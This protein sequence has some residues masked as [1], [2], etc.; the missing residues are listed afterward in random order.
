[1]AC[2]PPPRSSRSP[3]RVQE[4]RETKEER[5][6]RH[7]VKAAAIEEH[8]SK[9]KVHLSRQ[10]ANQKLRGKTTFHCPLKFDNTYVWLA[11]RCCREEGETLFVML[12]QCCRW[13]GGPSRVHKA[14][15]AGLCRG[16]ADDVGGLNFTG[17][18][19]C[20]GRSLPEVPVE[21]NRRRRANQLGRPHRVRRPQE[22]DAAARVRPHHHQSAAW[23]C[24]VTEEVAKYVDTGSSRD[25]EGP[26]AS[27]RH[28]AR[29][30]RQASQSDCRVAG[31]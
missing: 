8:R 23:K 2:P 28:T 31:A 14:V 10:N 26:L 16:V 29:S 7:A 22:P 27:S 20:R 19:R 5:E 17:C 21:P 11:Q 24:S 4:R 12:S 3:L 9:V 15:V 6:K 13:F 30:C 1:M 25:E 18:T